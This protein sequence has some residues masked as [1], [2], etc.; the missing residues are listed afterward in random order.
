M[1]QTCKVDSPYCCVVGKTSQILSNQCD[2][3]TLIHFREPE[4]VKKCPDELLAPGRWCLVSVTS[5]TQ[6]T[7]AGTCVVN[8]RVIYRHMERCRIDHTDFCKLLHHTTRVTGIDI[9]K[10]FTGFSCRILGRYTQTR[11]SESSVKT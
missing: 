7:G 1:T 10:L 2:V 9:S 5:V 4:M 3:V 6:S 8:P 11:Q